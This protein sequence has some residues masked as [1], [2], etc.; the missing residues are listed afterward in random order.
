MVVLLHTNKNCLKKAEGHVAKANE[1]DIWYETFG[2]EKNKPL[3][4][5]MGGCCQGVLWHRQ[6]CENLA[7]EGFYVIRYD[8][9]DS[10]LSSCFNYETNPYGLMDMAKDAVGLLDAIG[11]P[12]TH[13]F[14]VSVGAFLAEIMAGYFAHRVSSLLLLGSTCDIRSMN[15]AYAGKPLEKNAILS[16]PK[17]KYLD[18]MFDFMK[19]SPQTHEEKLAQRIEGWNQLSGHVFPLDAKI[20]REM[21]EEF[22]AR[23]RYPQG[24]L[25]HITMLNTFQS[26]ELVRLA[27]LKIQTPTVILHGSEDSVFPLD[28]GE[29]LSKQI[30]NSEYIPVEGMGHIPSNQF[31]DLYIE[32]LKQQSA[33]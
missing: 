8:H 12:K 4:L 10:G 24:I 28:H 29:A 19:H 11:I 6:F 16:P 20:N 14:G 21:Q 23:L 15:L 30:K 3:L 9:R 32:I 27:P 1:I 18:L 33:A 7:A 13:L 5:I 26:E 17:Q 22:L 2:D 31:Y 25:N